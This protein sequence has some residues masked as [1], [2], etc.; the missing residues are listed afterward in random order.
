V[1]NRTAG[2][3]FSEGFAGRLFIFATERRT[4]GAI[5]G[6]VGVVQQTR[7]RRLSALSVE[8][9]RGRHA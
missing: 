6:S 7:M 2:E 9:V 8:I 5:W 3:A 1:S 4:G